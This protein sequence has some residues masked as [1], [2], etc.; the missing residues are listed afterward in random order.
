MKKL[1]ALLLVCSMLLTCIG[2]AAFA[3]SAADDPITFTMFIDHSWLGAYDWTDEVAQYVT[4][5]TGVSLDITVVTDTSQELAVLV[6]GGDYPELIYSCNSALL[7]DPEIC[8][9]WSELAEQYGVDWETSEDEI[10]VNT[11]ADGDY[12][13]LK[14]VYYTQEEFE[15]TN[16][17]PG[18][19]T[20]SLHYREDLMAQLGNPELKTLDDLY[21]VL[22]QAKE[23][24]PDVIPL[25]WRGG[26]GG[27]LTEYFRSQFGLTG[28][29]IDDEG[30]VRY[31]LS[32][33]ALKDMY[34]YLNKLARAG[35]IAPEV[36]TWD[37]AKYYEIYQSGQGFMSCY[38]AG[39]AINSADDLAEVG[40]DTRYLVLPH[41][42]TEEA[43]YVSI[44]SGWAGVFVTK[45]CKDPERAAKFLEW[46]RHEEGRQVLTWG[47]PE[48][49]WY[50]DETGCPQYTDYALNPPEGVLIGNGVYIFGTKAEEAIMAATPAYPN[51]LARLQAIK[52]NM[53]IRGD[54]YCT[55]PLD[56]DELT[57]QTKLDT[58][59]SSEQMKLIFAETDADF[60]AA[61][62]SIQEK[63][64]QIGLAEFE[65]WMQAQYA[66]N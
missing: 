60:E 26:A 27:Y 17:M 51:R 5:K 58:M 32:N 59:I 29:W 16:A 13:T 28:R 38:S 34:A 56:G 53:T 2:T 45:N 18:I 25:I 39:G 33:P 49:H 8:Y 40:L 20:N 48:K 61:W 37:D 43:A 50:W 30:L 66:A 15:T 3:E 21:N 7:S 52:E 55:V 35:L 9:S 11:V 64:E 63:F 6:A 23:T 42:L 22:L 65:A 1:F 46:C 10:R 19:G 4:E 14:N 41:D 57:L 31:Y 36:V 62:E 44:P 54:L 24:F 47:I 12:Y